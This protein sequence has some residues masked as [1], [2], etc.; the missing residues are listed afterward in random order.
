ML[1]DILRY[2]K[3]EQHLTSSISVI[4]DHN[5]ATSN[6]S[7]QLTARIEDMNSRERYVMKK[8]YSIEVVNSLIHIIVIITDI[9]LYIII[10]DPAII[11]LYMLLVWF[12]L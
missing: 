1:N 7:S 8:S 3:Q 4:N 10:C 12:S 6:M 5:R 11:S 9:F 2:K